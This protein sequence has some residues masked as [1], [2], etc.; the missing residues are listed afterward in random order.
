MVFFISFFEGLIFF[1]F[2][3]PRQVI[4]D[5]LRDDAGLPPEPRAPK[6][7]QK[8]QQQHFGPDQ[9]PPKDKEEAE[10]EAPDAIPESDDEEDAEGNGDAEDGEEDELNL[11]DL[12]DGRDGG[13]RRG[14]RSTTRSARRGRDSGRFSQKETDERRKFF[15]NLTTIDYPLDLMKEECAMLLS[16]E[17]SRA[18]GDTSHVRSEVYQLLCENWKIEK[19]AAELANPGV[20]FKVPYPVDLTLTNLARNSVAFKISTGLAALPDPAS[21]KDENYGPKLKRRRPVDALPSNDRNNDEDRSMSL[22]LFDANRRL[23]RMTGENA[24]QQAV[25]PP[26][27]GLGVFMKLKQ[28]PAL[29]ATIDHSGNGYLKMLTAVQNMYP[30][31][32]TDDLCR[33]LGIDHV[34]ENLYR[35]TEQEKRR[36]QR[37][38]D[39]ADIEAVDRAEANAAAAFDDDDDGVTRTG[40]ENDADASRMTIVRPNRVPKNILVQQQLDKQ[41]K[42]KTNKKQRQSGGLKAASMGEVR[43]AIGAMRRSNQ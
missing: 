43:K 42:K 37:R 10:D 22:V 16:F 24:E 41:A 33:D 8:Q 20:P 6:K 31:R 34:A 4:R 30:D 13:R 26:K 17:K 32:H 35:P 18:S 11:D 40:Y 25:V 1:V 7:Q 39:E 21:Y 38:Q 14:K 5:R 2:F 28:H 9:G 19:A 36:L 12:M 29:R 23:A 27:T 15:S 3:F